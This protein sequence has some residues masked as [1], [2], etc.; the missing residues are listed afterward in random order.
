MGA[1]RLFD[2]EHVEVKDLE[3]GHLNTSW[4]L[5]AKHAAVSAEEAEKMLEQVAIGILLSCLG[6]AW[7]VGEE[8]NK[9]FPEHTFVKAEDYLAAVWMNKP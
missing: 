8:A 1:G 3:A 4:G 6:N 9:L 2:V 5:E 7:D